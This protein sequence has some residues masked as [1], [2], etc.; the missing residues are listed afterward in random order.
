MSI[1]VTSLIMLKVEEIYL[2]KDNDSKLRK[3]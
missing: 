2:V 3:L 1:T